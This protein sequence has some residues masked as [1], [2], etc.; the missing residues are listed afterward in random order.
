ME[1]K[2]HKLAIYKYIDYY[3]YYD[4]YDYTQNGTDKI[5]TLDTSTFAYLID[6]ISVNI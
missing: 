3:D 4:Y 1:D 5:Q 6:T 2:K